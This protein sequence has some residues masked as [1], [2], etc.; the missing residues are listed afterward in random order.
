[1]TGGM[2]QIPFMHGF[3]QFESNSQF[4]PTITHAPLA[5]MVPRGHLFITEQVGVGEVVGKRDGSVTE[6][7]SGSEQI[8]FM[9]LFT[10]SAWYLQF[11]PIFTHSPLTQIVPRRHFL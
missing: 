10:Q 4:L 3:V 5:Q 6:G 11:F 1:M 9:H 8:P 2:T 7:D